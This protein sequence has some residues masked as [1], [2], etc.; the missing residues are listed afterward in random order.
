MKNTI[1]CGISYN[2]VVL[3]D[4]PIDQLKA[5]RDA[6]DNAISEYQ[7]IEIDKLSTDIRA[8][9]DAARDA[10][11]DVF[12]DD[13]WIDDDYDIMLEADDDEDENEDDCNY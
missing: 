3:T 4:M 7:A 10:G 2:G 8:A 12:V 11:Y 5:M 6:I 13:H 1:K 9:I